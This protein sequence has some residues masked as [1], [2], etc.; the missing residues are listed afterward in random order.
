MNRTTIML[1]PD[2]K[3]RAADE[4]SRRGIS[5][6]ELIRRSLELNLARERTAAGAVDPLFADT[7]LFDG[8]TPDDLAEN[9]DKYLYGD[10]A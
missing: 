7:E 8:P 2:L 1:P 10:D 9:H 3:I 4:A 5:L 6:G